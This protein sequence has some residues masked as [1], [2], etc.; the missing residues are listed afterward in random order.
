MGAAR[1]VWYQYLGNSRI[2]DGKKDFQQGSY[3]GP[4]FENTYTADYPEKKGVRYTE[5]TD[6]VIPEK[7]R[8]E[9]QF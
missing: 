8:Y 9:K 5:L 1:F 7:R 2:T 3:L 4:E 6:E